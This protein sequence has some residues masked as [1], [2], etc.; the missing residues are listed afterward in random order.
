MIRPQPQ[1]FRRAPRCAIALALLF[2]LWTVSSAAQ[3]L[4]PR[5]FWPAPVG[6]K[7]FVLG[8]GYTSGDILLDPAVPLSGVDS[9]IH[10]GF[11]GYLST[12]GLWGRTANV[13]LELP[14][15]DGTTRATIGDTALRRD[16]SGVGDAGISLTVN[17]FGA[18]AM[19]AADF[20]ALR[21]APRPIVG[22]SLKVVPPSGHYELG[23]LI[24]VSGNRW[25]TR[26]KLGT[27]LP[28]HPKWL[29]EADLSAWW[30]GDDDDY[31]PGKREQAPVYAVETHLVRRFSPGFWASLEYNYYT[32]GGQTIAGAEQSNRQKNS[33]IGATIVI[34]FMGRNALKL[35]YSTG[36]RTRY[37]SD[38]GQVMATWSRFFN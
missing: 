15:S 35:G 10:T 28:L 37:G 12:F 19:S 29:L 13:L 6:T 14:Y 22:L 17:L 20:Q 23:R 30:Y 8:Y 25:A 2:A 1:S 34:P 31:L 7:V 38:Y 21:N 9:S 11:A 4:S 16:F 18:P 32:G 33:R 24:N 3:E 27:I 5:S 26:L 36:T